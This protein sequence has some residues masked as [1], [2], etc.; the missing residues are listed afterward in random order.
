MTPPHLLLI[1][2]FGKN[3]NYIPTTV[4][5]RNAR[6]IIRKYPCQSLKGMV[7]NVLTWEAVRKGKICISTQV[8]I[9]VTHP[10]RL[11]YTELPQNRTMK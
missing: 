7:G 5:Y 8:T 11:D 2:I 4:L 3:R 9:I 10:G 6:V 1:G